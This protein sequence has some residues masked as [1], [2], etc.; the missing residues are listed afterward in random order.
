VP[1][2]QAAMRCRARLGPTTGSAE[3]YLP[4]SCVVLTHALGAK[5]ASMKGLFLREA[6]NEHDG[7]PGALIETPR[8]APTK[9]TDEET[10]RMR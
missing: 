4:A 6:P 1:E 8:F 5:R 9:S 3:S 10:T 2:K 7:P